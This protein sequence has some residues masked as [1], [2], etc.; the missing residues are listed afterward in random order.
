MSQRGIQ[1]LDFGVKVYN[2]VEQYTVPQYGD[3]PNDQA[4]EFTVEDIKAQLKRYVNRIG[5]NARGEGEAFRDCLKIAHY[6]CLLH[7]QTLKEAGQ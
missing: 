6:A 4:S 2:H 3:M 5:T 1:W 7:A